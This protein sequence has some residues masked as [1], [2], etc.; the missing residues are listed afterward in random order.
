MKKSLLMIL[1][2]SLI[3]A[4]AFTL[5]IA[6]PS[7]SPVSA[8][9]NLVQN[10]GF[11]SATG[12]TMQGAAGRTNTTPVHVGSYAAQITGAGGS[13]TQVVNITNLLRYECWGWIYATASV[14]GRIELEFLDA[15][16]TV[17][18]TGVLSATNTNGYELQK[19]TMYAPVDATQLRI[20][21]TEGGTWGVGEEVRFDDIGAN[22]P[23]GGCFIATAAYGTPLVEEIEVLRQFRD[24]HLLTNPVGQLLVSLYYE[25]SPPLAH[26]ISK[27][28]GFRAVTRI[29]LEPII[30]FC[31]KITAPSSP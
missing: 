5:L 13:I 22:I 14:T 24:Q 21:L 12:W 3:L 9:G 27:H 8:A 17:V 11:E 19:L 4:T 18:R 31:S 7:V 20:R 16:S 6:A 2:L 1:A 30:W 23:W 29:A 15:N 25:S 28:E 26:L 10:P